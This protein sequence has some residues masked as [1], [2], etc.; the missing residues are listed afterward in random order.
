MSFSVR[1]TLMMDMIRI[2]SV[3][4]CV[5]YSLLSFT[6]LFKF[7]CIYPSSHRNSKHHLPHERRNPLKMMIVQMMNDPPKSHLHLTNETSANENTHQAAPQAVQVMIHLQDQVRH[8]MI[9]AVLVQIHHHPIR[10]RQARPGVQ[11]RKRN[12]RVKAPPRQI[13]RV[14]NAARK[15][16]E[17]Y[18]G[19]SYS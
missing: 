7:I 8:P 12:P 9:P 11:R 6:Q 2:R 16:C 5:F 13:R 3:K 17:I 19:K 18:I 15:Y 10:D 14:V 4:Y 1:Y